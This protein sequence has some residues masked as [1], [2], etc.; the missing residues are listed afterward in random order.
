LR[1]IAGLGEAAIVELKIV[2][3]AAKRFAKVKVENR[4]AMGSF[5]AVLDYCRTAMAFLDREEFRILFLDKK[6]LLITDEVQSTGTIDHAPV[7]PP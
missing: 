1:E 6:I 2:A 5:S 4:P 7:F 3:E